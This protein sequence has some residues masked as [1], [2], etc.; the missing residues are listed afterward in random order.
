MAGGAL[1]ATARYAIALAR[2]TPPD[3]W[4]WDTFV[5]NLFGAFALGALLETLARAGPDTGRRR[6]VRLGV[7]AGFLGAFTTYS[8]LAVE[9][10]LLVRDHRPGLGVAYLLLSAAAGVAAAWAGIV[11]AAAVDNGLRPAGRRPHTA[12][13]APAAR[14]P[15]PPG[16]RPR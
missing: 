2:P 13:T 3:G 10:D 14:S 6:A 16:R 12:R 5:T 9:A 11:A 1:G 7:G 15:R 8:T 4:P